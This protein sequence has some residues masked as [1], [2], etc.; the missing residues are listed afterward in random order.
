MRATG[1][2]CGLGI[3]PVRLGE[4]APSVPETR[5]KQPPGQKAIKE[6]ATMI[7]RKSHNV[8]VRN[9]NPNVAPIQAGSEGTVN[10]SANIPV[11]PGAPSAPVSSPVSSPVSDA[12]IAAVQAFTPT[13]ESALE[14]LL[15]ALPVEASGN[16]RSVPKPGSAHLQAIPLLSAILRNHPDLLGNVRADDIDAA[17]ADAAATKAL[18]TAMA[19]ALGK[20]D[21]A[22]RL[23]ERDAWLASAKVK[24][25]AE[26][27][28]VN[29][30]DIARELVAVTDILALGTR[31]DTAAVS[32]A[33]AQR[34]AA[35]AQARLDKAQQ[36]A[37][38]KAAAAGRHGAGDVTIVPAGTGTPGSTPTK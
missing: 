34:V 7:P 32:A 37:A 17:M 16:A 1:L 27:E 30:K 33:K 14:G 6:G 21:N 22:T 11:V 2:R 18:S 10:P 4:R 19:N 38:T 35:K 26:R 9:H 13:F 20:V 25:V 36:R 8:G 5:I 24:V 31:P 23:R 28:A 3:G 29:D 12:I 15:P